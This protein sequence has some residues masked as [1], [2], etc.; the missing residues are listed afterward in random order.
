MESILIVVDGLSTV[1]PDDRSVGKENSARIV[2]LV[3]IARECSIPFVFAARKLSHPSDSLNVEF[4]ESIR[5]SE[6]VGC[7]CA[8]PWEEDGFHAAISTANRPRLVIAGRFS[9]LCVS[10]TVLSALEEGY[11]VYVATD[12]IIAIS[13][14][15]HETAISRMVQAGAVPVTSRQIIH[16][17]QR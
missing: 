5:Q 11:E 16:E 17:W 12:A 13:K 4:K 8:N 3:N 1:M 7:D 6:I 14:Q 15:D 9:E 2:N 10:F